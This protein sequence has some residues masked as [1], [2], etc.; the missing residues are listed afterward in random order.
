MK[1][2]AAAITVLSLLAGGATLFSLDQQAPPAR[3]TLP[4]SAPLSVPAPVTITV[5]T[6]AHTTTTRAVSVPKVKV[7]QRMAVLD[8][9]H[10]GKITIK[11]GTNNLDRETSILNTGA[12][13]H[14][15]DSAKWF[16]DGVFAMSGHRTTYGAVFNKLD[17]MKKGDIATVTTKDGVFKY[18]Y[19]DTRIVTPDKM[20]VLDP[21][22]KKEYRHL[23]DGG[24]VMTACHPKHSARQRIV[25]LWKEI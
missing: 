6:T 8:L 22:E 23:K 9:P 5:P 25:V 4:V 11:Q 20:W 1:T 2:T 12:A 16:G 10:A 24:L 17:K 21:T 15:V 19:L 7:G 18:R 13:V 3:R 14:Y